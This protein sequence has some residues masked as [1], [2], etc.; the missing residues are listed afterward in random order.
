[1]CPV[2]CDWYQQDLTPLTLKPDCKQSFNSGIVEAEHLDLKFVNERIANANKGLAGASHIPAVFQD[3]FSMTN[4][5]PS[6]S[7]TIDMFSVL[8]KPL[9]AFNS[10]AN[11]IADVHPYVK[12]ALGIFTC[13]SKMILNQADHDVAVSLLS[14]I[15]EVYT[16]IMEEEE[17]AKIQSMLV[18][19][20]KIAQQMLECDDFIS[21][22]SETKSASEN[23]DLVGMEPSE[24]IQ[25]WISSTKEGA[26]C[27]LWLSGT[28]GKGKSAVAHTITNWYIEHSG[29][30]SCIMLLL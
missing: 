18:I 19:Y 29:L 25:N 9:K 10:I 24:G 1:M 8:L 7:D 6:V 28:A 12:V 13:T 23:L 30:S 27:I 3:T 11:T 15:S 22:Y 21:H 20:G 2:W 26:P 4:D 5:L 16:F 17:L 14:K